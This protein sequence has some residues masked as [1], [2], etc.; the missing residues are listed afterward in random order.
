M[1]ERSARFRELAVDVL[2]DEDPWKGR[3]ALAVA[4]GLMAQWLCDPSFDMVAD[5]E[6]VYELPRVEPA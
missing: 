6:R 2:G 4:E 5:L 1:Q 3:I